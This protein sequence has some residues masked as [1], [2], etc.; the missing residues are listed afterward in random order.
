MTKIPIE[1]GYLPLVDSAPL[2]IAKE[3]QF[4]AEEGLD[5]SLVRQP[6]W[7]ALRDMLAMG[8][9][10]F[11]HVLS[12]MPIAMSLGLGGMPAKIDALMV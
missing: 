11:A 9:L 5:L 12:P 1:C 10:D 2:I 8:R 7:S 3:L 4:A 6:S